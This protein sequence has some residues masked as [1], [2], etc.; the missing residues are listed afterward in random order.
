[1][2]KAVKPIK[3]VSKKPVLQANK[4][5]LAAAVPERRSSSKFKKS[6]LAALLL[7]V[8]LSI[9][10]FFG[11]QQ[12]DSLKKENQRLSDPQEAAKSEAETLKRKI[13][14]IIEVPADEEPI[15]DKVVDV[16]KAKKQS[17]FFAN[18]QEGDRLFRYQK[19]KKAI[20][21]RPSTNK[22]IEV[23]PLSVDK[24]TQPAPASAPQEPA[25][26]PDPAVETSPDTE[27]TPI[28]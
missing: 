2:A 26:A 10:G 5:P 11:Y 14:L 3:S 17:P 18:A 20:L 23:A 4:P 9:G 24:T 7:L 25:P 21:Y 27:F 19:A 1:M 22:I 6:Y 13:S 12:Y 28:E 15:I 16:E 8:L